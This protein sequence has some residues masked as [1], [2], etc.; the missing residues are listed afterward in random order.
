MNFV[1]IS[2]N[3]PIRYYLFVEAL[4]RKGVNVLGIGDSVNKDLEPRLVASLTEYYF[5][6]DLSD[7]KAMEEA[8][9]YYQ[10]KY[11]KID[12]IES[13]NEWWLTLDAHLRQKFNVTSGFFPDQ[14]EHIKA[15]SAMKEY[16]RQ[17]G[18]KTMRYILVDGPSD[19]QKALS[20]IKQVGYP[21]FVKPNVGVGA[22]DSYS[23]KNEKDVDAFFSKS[24]PETYIM[25]EFIDGRIV[26][27][28][29][30]CNSRGEVVF[31]TSDHFPVPVADVVNDQIDDYYWTNPFSL[32]MDDIDAQSFL[33]TG[34]KVVK[35]F[36]IS[37]RVFHIEF[38]VLNQDKPGFAKKGEF[39][40][41]E[42]NMR[43]AGGYTP[44]L[45]D[46]AESASIYDIYADVI[47]FDENR[48]DMTKEK[49]YSFTSARR[50]CYSYLHSEQEI[51]DKYRY[52]LT[53]HGR[54]PSHMA[55]AMGDSYYYA[56]FK[57]KE[58]GLEFVSFVR[59]KTK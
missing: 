32:P 33:E 4:R 43:P 14:M 38:F 1:F 36:G 58:E 25:E 7:E 49:Y 55:D 31:A 27:F 53:M 37:K 56:R 5:V 22:S 30:V 20:F 26:S 3:F 51:F 35:A 21:V 9:A 2:P 10:R 12:Y 46:F 23:L 39:V 42:C 16:F 40:A 28:D 13:N 50:D 41:L 57:T 18:A 24:L 34:K 29:G 11:G 48:E 15:K 47:C 19:K 54:Y 8:V 44:D 52:Q 17:G 59:A 6:K 45:I